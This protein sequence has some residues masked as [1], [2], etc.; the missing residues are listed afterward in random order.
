MIQFRDAL[1]SGIRGPEDAGAILLMAAGGLASLLPLGGGRWL[2]EVVAGGAGLIGGALIGERLSR[3]LRIRH[4]GLEINS[5]TVPDVTRTDGVSLGY[6]GDHMEELIVAWEEWLRHCVIAGQSGVGKTV[7]G[8]WLMLQQILRGGGLLWIDGKLDPANLELLWQMCNWCG[9]AD[10]LLVINPGNPAL[11]NTYNPILAGEP[12]EI[13]GRCLSLLPDAGGNAGAD[14]YRQSAVVAIAALVRAVQATGMAMDF[15]DLRILLSNTNALEWLGATLRGQ[16][17]D[18]AADEYDLWLGQYRRRDRK[19]GAVGVDLDA[20]KAV[21]GGIGARLTQF[22]AGGFGEVMNCYAPEVDLFRA[23]AEHKIVYAMLPTMGKPEAASALG[24]MIVGDF[25]TAI[26]K[27]QALPEAERPTV[28]FMAFYDEAGSYVTQSWSRMFEQARSARLVMVPAFQ[29][30]A[31][32]ETLG[33]DLLPMVAGNTYVKVLFKPGE[34]VTAKWMADL[35]GQEPQARRTRTAGLNGS[36]RVGTLVTG[37]TAGTSESESVAEQVGYRVTP[38]DLMKLG[39]GECIVSVGG[40]RL[41]KLR[42]PRVTF[43]DAYV[44]AIGPFALNHQQADAETGQA[45]GLDL[46]GRIREFLEQ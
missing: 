27:V 36:A 11:S 28:P 16:K 38:D 1:R 8:A 31:N 42:V 41:Y 22:A 12:D 40:E 30:K 34:P 37:P 2:P 10:D 18:D 25:R 35:L 3:E 17:H 4:A 29:T 14:Y 19:T 24:K 15:A 20:V 46:A 21:F 9:R 43:D 39:R 7:L 13:A 5:H 45:Q 23:V 44:K 26:A 33:G 32:L 6:V